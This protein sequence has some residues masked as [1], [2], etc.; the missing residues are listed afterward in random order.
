MS[1]ILFFD[2]ETTGL[3][4]IQNSIHQLSGII[5]INGDVKEVF[6]IKM[7]PR[8]YDSL[9]DDYTTPVGGVTKSMMSHYQIPSEAY[10]Q[11]TNIM[12]KYVDKFNKQ[13][14]FFAAGYN[15]QAFD[16]P[17]LREFFTRNDDKY[18]GSWFWSA[19]LDVMILAA[20]YLIDK[21]AEMPNFKLETV[22]S[23]LGKIPEGEGFHDALTDI[24]ITREIYHTVRSGIF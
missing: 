7:K 10:W 3:S 16:M 1:K 14:K 17:F 15:C 22:A 6:D 12:K 4:P 19:S 21:R 5:E 9:P 18:F 8:E 20:E 23:F 13:D 11:L 2:V 24:K